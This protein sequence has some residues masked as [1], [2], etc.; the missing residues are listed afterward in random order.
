MFNCIGSEVFLSDQSRDNLVAYY[1]SGGIVMTAS[2]DLNSLSGGAINA[3]AIAI[4]S[5]VRYDGGVSVTVCDEST[6]VGTCL[7]SGIASYHYSVHGQ[8]S[9]GNL[10]LGA[11]P[12]DDIIRADPSNR[13]IISGS[14]VPLLSIVLPFCTTAAEISVFGANL[15][16][17][18]C[19]DDALTDPVLTGCP[20][21]IVTLNM[22]DGQCSA[23][24]SFSIAVTDADSPCSDVTT[25]STGKA[26]G[27]AFVD[28][29][30]ASFTATDSAGN[31][32]TCSWTYSIVDNQPPTATVNSATTFAEGQPIVYDLTVSDNCPGATAVQTAGPAPG[33]TP[34]VGSYPVEFDL[35]DASGTVVAFP[36]TVAVA[37]NDAFS[38]PVLSGCRGPTVALSTDPGLCTA[39]DSFGVFATDADSPC[40]TVTL[41]MTGKASGAAFGDGDSVTFAAT[42][43]AGN[44][45]TCSWTYTIVD[46]ELPTAILN[47]PTSFL[48]GQP[49]SFDVTV[50]DN[51]GATFTQTIGPAPGSTPA[52]GEYD[53]NFQLQ[54]DAGNVV[55]FPVVIEVT[56]GFTV[57]QPSG[58]P[59]GNVY[60]YLPVEIHFDQLFINWWTDT[61]VRFEM[62][63]AGT[64]HYIS[65]DLPITS[66]TVFQGPHGVNP[67]E[68]E[69]W[70]VGM[71]GASMPAPDVRLCASPYTTFPAG[72]AL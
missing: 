46:D 23:I 48:L 19:C 10:V 12:G 16:R 59:E 13:F 1:N 72:C 44:S 47:S 17:C 15:A 24:H 57:T 58:G 54:D 38:T 64:P 34:G 41:T 40:A 4:G 65:E 70:V 5:P 22:N 36:F 39:T 14:S 45:A 51:C 71:S 25:T 27:S 68:Y 9:G 66:T 8:V 6:N 61:N 35:T 60:M 21:S 53:V 42:D 7:M 49:I 67:D 31:V 55:S 33:S 69:F 3:L 37:C 11:G 56:S 29:D 30:S 43:T 50:V 28:G 2:D 32:A 52:L 63:F 26:S 62:G 20:S 18:G